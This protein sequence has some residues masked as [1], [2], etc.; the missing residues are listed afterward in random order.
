VYPDTCV[1]NCGETL[2]EQYRCRYHNLGECN[3]LISGKCV[4]LVL[5]P[6]DKTNLPVSK[7]GPELLLQHSK[8]Y[9]TG[10]KYDVPGLKE[11]A[12]E[13]FR[14]C[15]ETFGTSEDFIVAAEHV[16]TTTPDDDEGLRGHVRETLVKNKSILARADVQAFLEVRP[17]LMYN[18]MLRATQ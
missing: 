8:M 18:I 5:D 1:L 9:T 14:R 16:F 12:R 15:C 7:G 2:C 3:F 17:A 6:V 4:P 11:L 13:K 10:D